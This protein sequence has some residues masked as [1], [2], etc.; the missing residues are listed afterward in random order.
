MTEELKQPEIVL[1]N[2]P[3]GTL[4]RG[5]VHPLASYAVSFVLAIKN[6]PEV[7]ALVKA[8]LEKQASIGDRAAVI[9]LP[10]LEAIEN[11]TLIVDRYVFGLAMYIMH[12]LENAKKAFKISKT[13]TS[14]IPYL[15]KSRKRL[16]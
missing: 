14:N 4:D 11:D 12:Y 7:W 15:F 10:T 6:V 2:G 13:L 8:D 16:P 3:I 9:C 5:E 1:E